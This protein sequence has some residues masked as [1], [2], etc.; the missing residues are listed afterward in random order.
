MMAHDTALCIAARDGNSEIVRALLRHDQIDP[1]LE[2]RWLQAPLALAAQGA[3][4]LVVDALLAD[5]RLSPCGLT[6]A[7]DFASSDSVR[8]V[9]QSKIDD[10]GT[11]HVSGPAQSPQQRISTFE[12]ANISEG[13]IGVS[14]NH[15]HVGSS[16]K[17]LI[18]TLTLKSNN[19]VALEFVMSVFL[20][21]FSATRV[22]W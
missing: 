3:H 13:W 1:N 16:H 6:R 15:K 8:T 14:V 21:L 4:L 12:M 19:L 7:L 5:R 10:F 2:N 11:H 17:L 9:I 20:F 22:S 18:T